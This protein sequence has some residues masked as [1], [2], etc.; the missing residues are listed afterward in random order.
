MLRQQI[1]VLVN[2]YHCPAELEVSFCVWFLAK[3]ID[4]P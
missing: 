2:K 1:W 3:I 4:A